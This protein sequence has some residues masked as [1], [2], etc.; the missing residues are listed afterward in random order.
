MICVLM[1]HAISFQQAKSH[2]CRPTKRHLHSS[3]RKESLTSLL[4]QQH[5]SKIINR[6]VDRVAQHQPFRFDG[7]QHGIR[8]AKRTAS[9]VLHGSGFQ[10]HISFEQMMPYFVRLIR[11]SASRNYNQRATH[12][13]EYLSHL[14]AKIIQKPNKSHSITLQLLQIS[15]TLQV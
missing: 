3:S 11:I 15:V 2:R 10:H 8:P 12:K 4:L 1:Q 5:S 6:Q 9:L 7:S 13:Q 14:R